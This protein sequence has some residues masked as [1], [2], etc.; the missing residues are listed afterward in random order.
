M[1]TSSI[2]TA[3]ED[4]N[5]FDGIVHVNLQFSVVRTYATCWSPLSTWTNSASGYFFPF[6]DDGMKMGMASRACSEAWRQCL[7]GTKCMAMGIAPR[8]PTYG[9]GS[10]RSGI[11]PR[12]ADQPSRMV[13]RPRVRVFHQVRELLSR[14][15]SCWPPAR[16]R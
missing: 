4:V 10:R 1:V 7:S 14:V 15:A 13:R 11:R 3:A 5:F 6:F 8:E 16:G 12:N 9:H 2:V